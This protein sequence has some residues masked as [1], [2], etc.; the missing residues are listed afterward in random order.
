M[1]I[2]NGI[3]QKVLDKIFN[4]SLLPN[5]PGREQGWD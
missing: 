3:P 5:P 4:P 1:K 2:G